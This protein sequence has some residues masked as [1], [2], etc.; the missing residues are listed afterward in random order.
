MYTNNLITDNLLRMLSLNQLIVTYMYSY[1]LSTICI[2]PRSYY[3]IVCC[4]L[5]I[6]HTFDGSNS[7]NSE[8]IFEQ[9]TTDLIL[10]KL[11]ILI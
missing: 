7:T 2:C 10:N 8:S 1:L 4:L 9:Q 6:I 3:S 11:E 5:Q